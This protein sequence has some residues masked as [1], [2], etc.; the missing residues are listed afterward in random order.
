MR[1]QVAPDTR[2]R[3]TLPRHKKSMLTSRAK[4][5]AARIGGLALRRAHEI[6]ALGARSLARVAQAF[7]L[8]LLHLGTLVLRTR[9]GLACGL[10]GLT[11][12]DELLLR[13]VVATARA[14][15]ALALH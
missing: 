15:I 6:C 12:L 13:L 7:L 8:R 9:R 2:S 10:V 14:V 1:I 5:K 4:R 11:G 3:A